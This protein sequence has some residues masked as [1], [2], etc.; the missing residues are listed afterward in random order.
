MKKKIIIIVSIILLIIIG[1]IFFVLN[2]KET[3]ELPKNNNIFDNSKQENNKNKLD[4]KTEKEISEIKNEESPDETQNISETQ[5]NNTPTP[6]PKTIDTNTGLSEEERFIIVE[7][8]MQEMGNKMW[9]YPP[10]NDEC[11]AYVPDEYK[12]YVTI[13]RI[14][15]IEEFY[16]Y[17]INTEYI[18]D[19]T[20]ETSINY[21]AY[22]NVN[23][24]ITPSYLHPKF[25]RKSREEFFVNID[26]N[27]LPTGAYETEHYIY[28]ECVP[29]SA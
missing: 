22:R 6:Q 13:V 9:P 17:N 10:S 29:S 26:T 3:K 14:D 25:L 15:R 4:N 23:D 2:N 24:Y 28:Y 18:D 20:K 1:I 27:N 5:Q 21:Y 19:E 8:Y 12:K 11:M 7:P 16:K